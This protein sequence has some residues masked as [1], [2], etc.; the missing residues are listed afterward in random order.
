MLIVD[1][2]AFSCSFCTME[3]YIFIIIKGSKSTNGIRSTSNTGNDTY[4][5]GLPHKLDDGEP[6]ELHIL[7]DGST[8]EVIANQ[9]TSELQY[10]RKK[11]CQPK[12]QCSTSVPAYTND[13][14]S[15]LRHRLM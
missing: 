5:Q 15:A 8:I 13:L 1:F 2:N 6:L 14:T 11:S 9:R 4:V 10:C 12:Y 7:L 3:L